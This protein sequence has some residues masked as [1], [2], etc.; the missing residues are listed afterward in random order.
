MANTIKTMTLASIDTDTL[1]GGYDLLSTA[2]FPP[3][4]FYMK[5][6]N[7]S[8]KDVEVSYDGK[9]GNDFVAA[10]KDSEFG[11]SI[12][13]EADHGTYFRLFTKIFVKGATGGNDTGNIYLVVRYLN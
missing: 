8:S 13:V 12:P 10:S 7:N 5:I 9:E 2:G 1:T 6:I 4:V 11:S 3:R